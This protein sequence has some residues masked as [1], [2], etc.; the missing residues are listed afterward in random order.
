[1]GQ[2]SMGQVAP[3]PYSRLHVPLLVLLSLTHSLRRSTRTF[4]TAAK[5]PPA[6]LD[7]TRVNDADACTIRA[8]ATA[9]LDLN[10]NC[11]ISCVYSAC[12][13]GLDRLAP[14][15]LFDAPGSRVAHNFLIALKAEGCLV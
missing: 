8:C 11:V 1:M 6:C 2:V 14:E 7:R 4:A 12:T 10:L 5:R 15:I 3:F 9:G 13:Q